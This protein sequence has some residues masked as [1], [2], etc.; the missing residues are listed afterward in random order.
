MP[1]SENFTLALSHFV[2]CIL[3]RA[4]KWRD[5]VPVWQKLPDTN[6]TDTFLCF[7]DVHEHAYPV[8]ILNMVTPE[9]RFW[10]FWVFFFRRGCLIMHV[11]C[12]YSKSGRFSVFFDCWKTCIFYMLWV[13]AGLNKDFFHSRWKSQKFVPP[14]KTRK[15]FSFYV[16][17]S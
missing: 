11:F 14:W 2:L 17:S 15:F 10:G 5:A 9:S 6:V 7:L 12:T 4:V 1:F 3:E 16:A 8:F 13:G